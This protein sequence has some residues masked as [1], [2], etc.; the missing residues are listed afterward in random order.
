[1]GKCGQKV[2]ASSCE[3][4]KSWECSVQHSDCS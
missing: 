1:M 4:N 3:I 2:H